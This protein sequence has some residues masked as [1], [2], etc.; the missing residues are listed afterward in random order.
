MIARAAL[1]VAL[2]FA[3]VALANS[4]PVPAN[5]VAPQA[6]KLPDSAA[7]AAIK[8]LPREAV[9]TPRAKRFSLAEKA[10]QDESAKRGI[11]EIVVYGS[12]DPEDFVS[13]RPPMLAFRDRLDRTP[14]P[15]T[16]AQ[17]AQTALCLVGLC[18]KGYG[19]EGIPIEDTVTTR[20]EKNKDRSA[21]QQTL[22][23]R[24]TYQ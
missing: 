23:F 9:N 15:M 5:D 1:L 7:H 14:A 21:L 16:P 18:S 2:W 19:P 22:Q 13:K 11:D 12:A 8:K 20:A 10:A 6:F 24:G 3:S 17:I 4:T